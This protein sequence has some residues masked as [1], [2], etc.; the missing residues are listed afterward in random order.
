MSLPNRL[1]Y[2]VV[3]LCS[4]TDTKILPNLSEAPLNPSLVDARPRRLLVIYNP[5]AG[6]WQRRRYVRVL[7]RLRRFGC[8]I[9]ERATTARGD[10][11]AF[12]RAAHTA[13]Y[14]L[15]VAAGGDG[16][17]NEVINGL[18]D[19]AV[20]LAILPLGTANVLANEIGLGGS[21]RAVAEAIAHLEPRPV[22]LGTANGRHFA[23]MVGVGFDARV[24]ER[25]DLRLKRAFGKL[26]YALTALRQL[27]RYRPERYQVDVDGKRFTAA[28]VVIAK[29]HFYGGR[30]IVARHARLDEPR[31]QVAL[32]ERAG[33]TCCAMRRHSSPTASPAC[34]TCASCRRL[35]SRCTVRTARPCRR[36]AI[37]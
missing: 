16:T 3:L 11:E 2:P 36:T 32:F 30:F 33:G 7:A 20:P 21:A 19:S 27:F 22:F 24:V 29:G 23:L 13:D 26:A 37:S 28:A 34:P 18:A 35:R 12:A 25:V 1:A 8:V 4:K 31:L 10:A 5:T 9:T 17:I 15:V 14:D 6:L